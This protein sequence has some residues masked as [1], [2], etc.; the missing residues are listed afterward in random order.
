M[1]RQNEEGFD[2]LLNSHRYNVSIKWYHSGLQSLLR[3]KQIYLRPLYSFTCEPSKGLGQSLR[4]LIKFRNE[5]G[6]S[7]WRLHQ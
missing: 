6:S 2:G 1:E 7:T 4:K 5:V 3:L